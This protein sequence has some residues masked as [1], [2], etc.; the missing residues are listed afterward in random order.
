MFTSLFRHWRHSR[1]PS[2]PFESNGR[3]ESSVGMSWLKTRATL[4]SCKKSASWRP[5]YSTL[6]TRT[7][8]PRLIALL[9]QTSALNILCLFLD[10]SFTLPTV[11]PYLGVIWVDSVQQTHK[12]QLLCVCMHWQHISMGTVQHK[13]TLRSMC[14]CRCTVVM[15]KHFHFGSLRFCL[16]KR[17]FYF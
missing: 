8:P 7:R 16:D 11:T 10:A 2:T 4:P 14:S 12:Q 9:A 15:L 17:G 13:H 3:V 1:L 5:S 6:H